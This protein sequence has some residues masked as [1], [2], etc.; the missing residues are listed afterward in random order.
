MPDGEVIHAD[1]VVIGA[2]LGGL[3]AAGYLAKGGR[4]VVVLEHHSVPGGYAHEFKRRGFRFEVALHALD[5]AGPG[6]WLH[7]MLDDLGVLDRVEFVRLD[8]FYTARF[9]D[10]EITVPSDLSEYLRQLENDFSDEVDGI[11]DLF[12]AIRRVA[13]D[14]GRFTKDRKAGIRSTPME[15]MQRYP[16]MAMAFSQNWQA[17]MD[18]FIRDQRLQAVI[19]ALWGYL[20]L[21]PSKISAGLFAL[22]L[23][24]YHMSGAWYPRGGSQAMSRAMVDAIVE[25]G[26]E[27]RFRNTVTKID[28]EDTRA[29]AIETDR[30]LRVEAD[31]FIS[32][33]SPLAT[34]TLVGRDHFDDSFLTSVDRDVPALSNLVVYLGLDRD[35]VAQGW[36]HH[37]FF[38]SDGFDIEADYEAM[39]VGDFSKAG[40]VIANYTEADPGC[41]PKGKSI[42]VIVSLAA[43]SYKDSWGTGGDLA[44]YSKNKEYLRLKDEAAD[45]LIDRVEQLIP[46]LRDSI[47]VKEVATPLTNMRY[48]LNPGGSIYGREQ[49]VENMMNRRSS[50]SPIPN[51]LFAGAW[52]GGG[53]MS[54]AI[55]SGRGAASAAEKMLSGQ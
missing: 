16:D 15:M 39:M 13:H 37:E 55:A 14:M 29:V 12:A 8:P 48:G 52:V 36:H 10:Y 54:A 46:G 31:L 9:S 30:G 11:A 19:S 40:L 47:I 17:F 6:G 49:T 20:G 51:L 32:N 1:A 45:H 26:G 2:G 43:W 18:R 7:P 24:S 27:V 42:L 22:V 44:D 35:L 4:K 25:R 38:L 28:V 50:K 5:G 33:A 53:G 34:T 23:S 41:A 3:S 21:P